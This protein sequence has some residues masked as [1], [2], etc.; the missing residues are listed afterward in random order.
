MGGTELVFAREDAAPK[1]PPA[2][3]L[4]VS[5]EPTAD[6][7]SHTRDMPGVV[8]RELV[9]LRR[10]TAFSERLLGSSSRDELL[11]SLMDEAIEVTRA[12]KGFLILLEN[13][14]LR[15]KVARNLIAGEHRGRDGAG[16]RLDRREGGAARRKPLI[17]SDALDDPEFKASKSVVNLK[18]LSVMCVPLVRKGELFGVLYVGNDR[19]VNRFEPKSLDML[20]IFAAQALA[21]HPERAAGERAE[22]GQHRAAQAAGRHRTTATSSAR[23][24]ACWTCTGASTRSP[25]RTSRC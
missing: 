9:L 2:P 19:L 21:A 7:D 14:E 10:L 17:L 5:R 23:A 15:V 8:G 11:E 20:T 1:P 6:P 25:P 24:R 4:S 18:L 16:V 12:D 13:G 3:A 22:A